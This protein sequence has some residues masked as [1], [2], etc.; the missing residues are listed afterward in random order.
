MLWVTVDG[1]GSTK[2][3][4]CS[5]MMEESIESCAWS[6]QCFR[7]CFRVA[8]AV[9]FSDSAPQLKAA[10][11]IVFPSP[12]TLHLYCIW[13]L[14]NNMVTNLKAACGADDSLWQRVRSKWWHI[15]KQSDV[16]SCA[17]FDSD[18]ASL[19]E[20]LDEST[21]GA[22]AKSMVT[23]RAWLAKLTEE[24][25]HWA[26]RYTWRTCTL[27]LHSTQRIE[28]VHAAI[29]HFLRAST[30]LT[31]LL[32]QLEAYA[33]DVNDRG[34]V[35]D[36]RFV[37]RLLAAADACLAHPL[38]T[39][40]A[41][42]VTGY[43]LVLLKVQLQ[44]ASFYSAAP[45]PGQE[46]TYIV[47]RRPGTWGVAASAEELSGDADLGIAA[48][49]Y[50]VPRRTTLQSCSCQFLTC[51]GLPC[52]H[53][54]QVYTLEQAELPLDLFDGRWKQRSSAEVL[55]AEQALLQRRPARGAS[56]P[57]SLPD[58][59]E[60]Y[61]LIVAA[62]RGV[63][64]VGAATMEGYQASIDGLA[65]LL[66]KLRLPPGAPGAAAPARRLRRLAA[67]AKAPPHLRTRRLRLRSARELRDALRGRAAQKTH[68]A[69]RGRTCAAPCALANRDLH[70]RF[71]LRG[72][73][74]QCLQPAGARF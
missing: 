61:G 8:P 1:S 44:Q 53:M 69:R 10:I 52:R 55:A 34:S 37:Q 66:S 5:L 23:A 54:L 39:A 73:S 6:C 24:R 7:D 62:A 72:V 67:P 17:T 28:A 4:A 32:S 9:I 45:V 74:G 48:E 65:Q 36:Y 20:L 71:A 14:S 13:H 58:R 31:N 63:A 41:S 40:L 25:E 42:S 3:L 33:F 11:A 22:T 29:A 70:L 56:G 16:A 21:V 26:Y 35:R 19:G 46:G 38:I 59:S 64:E 43:A 27:G 49:L 47:T 18:M 50:S 2:I 57:R 12:D 60:R 30:L 51:Y 15:A 68:R